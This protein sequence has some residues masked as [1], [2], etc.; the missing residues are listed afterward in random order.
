MN[1]FDEFDPLATYDPFQTAE[2]AIADGSAKEVRVIP[3]ASDPGGVANAY[4]SEQKNPI[5]RWRDSWYSWNGSYW[6]VI[7]DNE[8]K[9]AFNAWLASAVYMK[10][11]IAI[12]WNPTRRKREEVLDTLAIHPQV[13][14]SDSISEE[15]RGIP[16][17]NG[18][19]S[20][21]G[22]LRP[23]DNSPMRTWCVD[24]DYAPNARCPTWEQFMVD[25]LDSDQI[26]LAQEWAGYVLSGDVRAHKVMLA[27]GARRAGKSTYAAILAALLGDCTAATTPDDMLSPFGLEPISSA[28]LV[29]MGDVRWSD[30]ATRRM[31]DRVRAIS[32]GDAQTVNRK[33]RTALQRVSL[34]CRFMFT[35][36][37]LPAFGD[38]SG[39]TLSRFLLLGFVHDHE[40]REDYG[41][42]EKLRGELPGIARWSLDGYRRL[43][44]R[45]L[46]F[47]EP[48][49][50]RADRD[51]LRL[52]VEPVRVFCTES[53]VYDETE[54][55][56]LVDLYHAFVAWRGFEEDSAGKSWFG[57]KVKAALPAARGT[58]Q[59][60]TRPRDP[61]DM[62]QG[63]KRVQER[64]FS[65]IR[66]AKG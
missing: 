39:A 37:D 27:H 58:R 34:P 11:G 53:V 43:V 38:D 66:L 7:P 62:F 26:E 40:G 6:C 63:T 33:F 19:L 8:L 24:A 29:T 56:S 65:G 4:L 30:R 54:W 45:G 44:D 10:D 36:N 15:T 55:V 47:V 9:S 51:D 16:F 60:V 20:I 59:Y 31:L 22:V 23:H 1:E 18:V 41:L 12:P 52:D 64:G 3:P 14:L 28:R 13:M 25:A 48:V 5:R 61:Y 57:R 17:R 49:R 2:T 42:L 32:G 35:S 50:S 46:H 21:D